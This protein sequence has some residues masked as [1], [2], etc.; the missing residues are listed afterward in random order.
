MPS[1]DVLE[2]R[3]GR[4]VRRTADVDPVGQPL[5]PDPERSF[6]LART[7]PREQL[8]YVSGD[9]DTCARRSLAPVW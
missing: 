7:H 9:T 6:N 2:W 5:S 3:W 8:A 1:K 4:G